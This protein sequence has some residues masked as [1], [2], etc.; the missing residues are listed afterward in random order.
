M[1]QAQVRH[2]AGQPGQQ[3]P[4]QRHRRRH[5]PRRRVGRRHARRARLQRRRSSRSTTRPAARTRIAAQGGINAAKNYQNDGDSVYRLFYDTVKGGDYR[6]PRGQR[7]PAGRRCRSTSS[8]SASP[9]ACRSPAS[10]AACSTTARSAAPRCPARSTPA[11]RPASSCCSARTRRSRAR[12]RAG[13]VKLSPASEMLDLVVKDGRAVRHRRPRPGHRRDHPPL[14]ARRGA[15]H[16]R[17]RQRLLPL[18]QRQGLAT[19]PPSG[20]R[21]A[22]GACFANPCYTQIHPTCI[23]ASRRLPVEAHAD[24]ASRCATTAASGCRSG[25]GDDRARR[26]DPRGRARLLPRAQVPGVRQPRRRATSRR[27]RAKAMVDEGRGVGPLKNGVYL[28][29][30][31]RHRAARRSDVIEER[32]G[33]L[34]EMYERITDEDPYEVP[35]RIY[36]AV[37]YTMGGLWVD[38]N[39]MTT[40]PRPVRARRGQ[41]LRPRR[42]PARRVGAD[43]GP[44][45]RLL[46]PPVHDRRLPR[47][48]CSASRRCPTDDPAFT[49]AEADVA[50]PR[51]PLLSIKRQ[52]HR[53]PLPPR[54]RQDHVGLLRHGAQRAGPREGAVARSPRCARSSGRDVRVLGDGRGS[55]SRSRRP[56]GSPTS[57]SSAS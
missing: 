19:S 21:T 23:P 15:R 44:G 16:R 42:Q 56:A 49:A 27:A 24:V 35:M 12:S 13:T 6:S 9:R 1:G 36:P 22:R 55:T 39:L 33:N 57:S 29:F 47:A 7:L 14:G 28:D 2:E 3:A 18:D 20:G 38:Y 40:D 50:R 5:R 52:A 30:A 46:R 54:A 34:F 32:Y 4:V 10:T 11:A 48:G 8:T 53:R 45:R 25:I 51:R 43:A 31:R 41:L 37:H 17:L 26:P